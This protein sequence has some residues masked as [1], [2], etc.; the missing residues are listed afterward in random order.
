ME[1]NESLLELNN[2]EVSGSATLLFGLAIENLLKAIIISKEPK[3]VENGKLRDWPGNG[4]E[5]IRLAENANINLNMQQRDLLNRLV[6]FIEWAGRYPV[7][8]KATKIPLKQINIKK[9]FWPLPLQPFERKLFEQLF[10]FLWAFIF[11][12][13]S[14]EET[15]A[16]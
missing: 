16:S 14:N 3:P 11:A 6:A 10:D 7:P 12:D 9:H 15:N 2:L 1:D 8:K 13:S 5:L 4:H